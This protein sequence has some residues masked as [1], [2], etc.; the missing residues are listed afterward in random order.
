MFDSCGR[1]IEDIAPEDEIV[2]GMI[3]LTQK[4]TF[5]SRSGD[6]FGL[7]VTAL[8]ILLIVCNMIGTI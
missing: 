3:D 2:A 1:M 7:T 4:E 8:Y 6:I 5:Y